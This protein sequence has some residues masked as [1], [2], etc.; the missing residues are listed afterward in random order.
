[1]T[2]PTACSVGIDVSATPLDVA[3]RPAGRTW[4]APHAAAGHAVL[5]AQRG[6]LTP[7]RI[8]LE[9][10]GGLELPVTAPLAAASLAVAVVTPRQVRDLARAIG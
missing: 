6:P 4:R 3:A 10:T 2:T 9:V 1:M 5:I 8:V 7:P